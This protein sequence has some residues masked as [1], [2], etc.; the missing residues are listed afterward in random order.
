L[1]I[2]R[3]FNR[4]CQPYSQLFYICTCFLY[5]ILT[6]DL[7]QLSRVAKTSSKPQDRLSSVRC[8]LLVTFIRLISYMFIISKG[9]F[10]KFRTICSGFI[11]KSII[12]VQINS[13]HS[14]VRLF[15]HLSF[16]P[17]ALFNCAVL[18]V[19]VTMV[20]VGCVRC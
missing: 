14:F 11:L 9:I 6:F 17:R 18:I 7:T 5:L 4:N 12:S 16:K 15:A 2:G 1:V 20:S 19:V 13:V 10:C 3:D 8:V